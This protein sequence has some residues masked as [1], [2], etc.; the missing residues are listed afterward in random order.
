LGA[1]PLSLSRR[2]LDIIVFIGT[3]AGKH[4]SYDPIG[5]RLAFDKENLTVKRKDKLTYSHITHSQNSCLNN[6][7]K[8]SCACGMRFS[9]I[10]ILLEHLKV[11]SIGI[12][13]RRCHRC[14]VLRTFPNRFAL[15]AHQRDEH[16]SA[17]CEVCGVKFANPKVLARHISSKHANLECRLCGTLCT[18]N[19]SLLRHNRVHSKPY[20]C[21]DCH[22][23]FSSNSSLQ[24]HHSSAHV[25]VRLVCKV[26]GKGYTHRSNL[27]MHIREKHERLRYF[28]SCGW[29]RGFTRKETL[30]QHIRRVHGGVNRK[31]EV[32]AV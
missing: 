24:D 22:L 1:K 11:C 13:A 6:R 4:S 15:A 20:L 8:R 18:T 26:C 30:K 9:K 17:P 27:R 16:G 31:Y 23:R 28:C 2:G 25:G 19:N 29:A 12:T 3:S 32:R 21:S 7:T 5:D 14:P 10:S